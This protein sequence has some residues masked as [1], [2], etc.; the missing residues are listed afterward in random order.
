M[1]ALA[2]RLVSAHANRVLK[3]LLVATASQPYPILNL[4]HIRALGC[5]YFGVVRPTELNWNPASLSS[6]IK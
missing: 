5:L 6:L 2:E 1:S 4:I 3:L